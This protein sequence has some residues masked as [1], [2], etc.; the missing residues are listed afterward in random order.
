MAID[1]DCTSFALNGCLS[2]RSSNC[3]SFC[4]LTNSSSSFLSCFDPSDAGIDLVC[5]CCDGSFINLA[6]TAQFSKVYRVC[7][8][9][10]LN[11]RTRT[12][13]WLLGNSKPSSRHLF[14]THNLLLFKEKYQGNPSVSSVGPTMTYLRHKTVISQERQHDSTQFPP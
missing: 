8:A 9:A 10:L 1:C 7:S 6:S 14:S 5:C 4:C 12:C 11:G 3:K 13:T 2:H